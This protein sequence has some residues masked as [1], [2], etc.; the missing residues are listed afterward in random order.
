V[1]K[2]PAIAFLGPSLPAKEARRLCPHLE[3]HPPARQ[4]DV[5]RVLARRP[6]A[7]AL[8]D[9]VFESQ[10]SVWHREI[11]AAL[12]AGIPVLGGGSLGALRAA[13][14][15]AHGMKGIGQIFR[16]YRDETLIDDGEVALLHADAEHH[17]RA[18]TVP[19]VN[20]R[21]AADR[22]RQAKIIS[23][24][25]ATALVAHAEKIFYQERH[26][27]T[28]LEPLSERPRERWT[29]WAKKHLPDLKAE[30]ARAVL[31]ALAELGLRSTRTEAAAP[32]SPAVKDR[33]PP[34]HARRRRLDP[35]TLAAMRAR[36]DAHDLTRRGLTRQLLAGFAR[37]LGLVPSA[38]DLARAKQEWLRPLEVSRREEP[39]FLQ[40]SDLDPA[41][42][43]RLIAELALEAL[44]LQHA[45]RLLP[46]APSLEE[47]LASEARRCGHWAAW[48]AQ[49]RS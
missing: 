40:A 11:L 28:L 34:A 31:R 46:D 17:F 3:L 49:H 6:R 41:E 38:D 8:I 27:P 44:A 20:V 37:S 26:W 2:N 33:P 32:R 24:K 39:G 22:A 15:E 4:G 45:E 18:F 47:A 36:E 1:K 13:E 16:W 19:L 14:L 12:D 48:V 10:P 25:E 35:E 21:H 43:Q 42:A 9:G 30:D 23:A 7:I 5:W 29:T